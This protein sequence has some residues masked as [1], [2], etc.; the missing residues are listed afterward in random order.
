MKTETLPEMSILK[1]SLHEDR[2][3]S[4]LRSVQKYALHMHIDTYS[5]CFIHVVDPTHGKVQAHP[6]GPGK[7]GINFG[8]APPLQIM[9]NV[10]IEVA[11]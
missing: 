1:P 5:L 10:R 3:R 2:R 4:K 7:S 9:H 6:R 11:R 8:T